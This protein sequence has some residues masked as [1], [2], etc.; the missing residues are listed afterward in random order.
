MRKKKIP[1]S[2]GGFIFLPFL[3]FLFSIKKN[4]ITQQ[5]PKHSHNVNPTSLGDKQTWK[6][7]RFPFFPCFR[8]LVPYLWNTKHGKWLTLL[9]QHPNSVN[10][11]RPREKQSIPHLVIT[12]FKTWLEAQ[13]GSN[14]FFI[15]DQ[16]N[17]IR[18]LYTKT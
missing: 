11:T 2:I 16:K 17:P 4:K 5:S 12:A 10:Q 7:K 18:S 6:M 14:V 13:N 3:L 9:S 1:W 15:N 8:K